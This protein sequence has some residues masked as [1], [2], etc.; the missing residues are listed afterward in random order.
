[1]PYSCL[2]KPFACITVIAKASPIPSMTVLLAD[3]VRPIGHGSSI[4]PISMMMSA[5]CRSCESGCDVIPM[6]RMSPNIRLSLS[7]SSTS[8]VLPLVE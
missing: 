8:L 5:N 4:I 2:V 7:V 3:G 6:I 1:M